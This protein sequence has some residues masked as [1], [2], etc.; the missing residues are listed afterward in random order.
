MADEE[1]AASAKSRPRAGNPQALIAA[2]AL[3]AT[4]SCAGGGSEANPRSTNSAEPAAACADPG[5]DP[6]PEYEI[7]TL[8]NGQRRCLDLDQNSMHDDWKTLQQKE[9]NGSTNQRWRIPV[10]QG[11]RN[12]ANVQASNEL[13]PAS[14]CLM[15]GP[16]P[17]GSDEFAFRCSHRNANWFGFPS[18]EIKSYY[19][20]ACL[21]WKN[22][23][24]DPGGK[25]QIKECNGSPNQK[26]YFTRK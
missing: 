23:H 7:H 26:W 2:L 3:V 6:A 17:M 18:G 5:L 20:D 19:L 14:A 9:C 15:I 22:E 10:E 4:T 11:C 24:P 12:L 1:V 25:V 13:G 8:V 16:M 21:D